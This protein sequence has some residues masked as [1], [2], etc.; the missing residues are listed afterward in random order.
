MPRRN[1]KKR[2]T[3]LFSRLKEVLPQTFFPKKIFRD[4]GVLDVF[5]RR[6]LFFDLVTIFRL[7]VSSEP[8]M[9]QSLASGGAP[10][11]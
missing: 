6:K 9:I 5:P 7:D 1:E 3:S 8:K 10:I 11:G 2:T 4:L